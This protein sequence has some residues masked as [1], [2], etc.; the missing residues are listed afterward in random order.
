MVIKFSESV[1]D[2][3]DMV[4]Q[5][6]TNTYEVC[7]SIS[8][9]LMKN[10]SP[11]VSS[12]PTID[13]QHFLAEMEKLKSIHENEIYELREEYE[14]QLDKLENEGGTRV[15]KEKLIKVSLFILIIQE[16]QILSQENDNL[17]ER[18]QATETELEYVKS[19][20]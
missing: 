13:H 18:L 20:L 1:E 16:M 9:G 10:V 11:K 19:D 8:E 4:L 7:R 5:K 2:L 12:A 3:K 15:N 17:L 6:L 14:A